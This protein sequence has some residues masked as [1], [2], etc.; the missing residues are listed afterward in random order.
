MSLPLVNDWSGGVLTGTI[1]PFTDYIGGIYSGGAT[2]L[3]IQNYIVSPTFYQAL[4]LAPTSDN[5]NGPVQID[6]YFT[7]QSSN[8]F[9][10]GQ[11]FRSN[12]LAL[13]DG[14]SMYM[15]RWSGSSISVNGCVNGAVITSYSNNAF[16]TSSFSVVLN[17]TYMFR[18]VLQNLNTL[19]HTTG[20]LLIYSL[21][22]TSGGS[23]TTQIGANYLVYDPTPQLQLSQVPT[24]GQNGFCAQT[25]FTTA[26]TYN[27]VTK[28]SISVPSPLNVNAAYNGLISY[29]GV[30]MAGGAFGLPASS[31]S[32]GVFCTTS[33]IDYYATKNM[34]RIRIPFLWQQIQRGAV[35]NGVYTNTPIS[36]DVIASIL[37]LTNYAITNYNMLVE[38]DCH[39]FGAYPDSVTGTAYLIG[40]ATLPNSAFGNLWA[41]LAP[42]AS[43]L[44]NVILGTMNE[45]NGPAQP[46]WTASLQV[47][48]NAIRAT[49]ST[50][51]ISVMGNAYGGGAGFVG[52]T[53]AS[54]SV[55][56]LALTDSG[57]NLEIQIHQYI[58]PGLAGIGPTVFSEVGW[59]QTLWAVTAWAR[60]N[61]INSQPIKLCLGEFGTG[62]PPANQTS[63]NALQN[64]MVFLQQNSDVW[65][66]WTYWAGGGGWPA[67]YFTRADPIPLPASKTIG[68]PGPDVGQWTVL[69]SDVPAQSGHGFFEPGTTITQLGAGK[70]SLTAGGRLYRLVSV[71]GLSPVGAASDYVMAVFALMP[72]SLIAS[73]Q[74][75]SISASGSFAANGDT[76][77]VKLWWAPT[78]A[79]IG[80][81]ITGGTVIGDT[82]ASTASGSSWLIEGEVVKSGQAGSNTQL[83]QN[84][85]GLVGSTVIGLGAITAAAA[86]ETGQILIAVTGNATTTN[87]DIVLNL[88]NIEAQN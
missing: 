30:N 71:I 26:G 78:A 70:N 4:L 52:T 73:G 77:E 27:G 68:I 88:F 33:Q 16:P 43:G 76:K 46:A 31:N 57:N 74:K 14:G 50:N 11:V 28:L 44:P 17:S 23:P 7:G 66:S 51:C 39:N 1:A 18:C 72:N 38:W 19:G 81:A 22:N 15:C 75:L 48:I 40:S 56:M 37:T 5:A 54:N 24:G 3:V 69:A 84:L 61:T 8:I 62:A 59:Q 6:I 64:L 9:Q 2:N 63:A 35:A 67:S 49:G 55:A 80:S 34:R 29:P 47:C 21:W 85:G 86:V 82:G 83:V 60:A 45:P 20:V 87:T 42:Y 79:V 12:G 41:A 36:S 13:K 53:S 32:V 58:D 65:Y 25:G 10:L